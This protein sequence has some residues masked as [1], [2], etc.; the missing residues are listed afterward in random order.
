MIPTTEGV[1]K[2]QKGKS[3]TR[4]TAGLKCPSSTPGNARQHSSMLG[5]FAPWRQIEGNWF[6][7]SGDAI[8]RGSTHGYEINLATNRIK[9]ISVTSSFSRLTPGVQKNKLMFG[10]ESF[11]FTIRMVVGVKSTSTDQAREGP[12]V[13]FKVCS[14]NDKISGGDA[15]QERPKAEL[16]PLLRCSS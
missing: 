14:N 15:M 8:S 1:P 7:K 4:V 16:I 13:C 11:Q 12:T 9:M 10:A 3:S 2:L 5:A 6:G